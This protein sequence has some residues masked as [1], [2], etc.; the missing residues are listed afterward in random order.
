MEYHYIPKSNFMKVLMILLTIVLLPLT[1]GFSLFI[2]LYLPYFKHLKYY[3][4]DDKLIIEKGLITRKQFVVPLYRIR[5]MSSSNSFGVGTIIISDKGQEFKLNNIKNV[6]QEFPMLVDKWE[7]AKK[8]N[9]R[10]EVI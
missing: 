6:N 5:N 10:N 2:L 1:F 9:I 8:K 4:N 7:N 3:Y